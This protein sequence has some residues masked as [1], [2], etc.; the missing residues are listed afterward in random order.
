MDYFSMTEME[1]LRQFSERLR[2]EMEGCDMTQKDLAHEAGLSEPTISHYLN[3]QRLPSIKSIVNICFV[4]GID[5]DVL[6]N[7]GKSIE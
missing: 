7:F 2:E 1:W 4:L 3:A 6:T 5:I